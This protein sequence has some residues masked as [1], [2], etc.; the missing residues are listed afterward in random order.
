MTI[1][2][3]LWLHQVIVIRIDFEQNK[4]RFMYFYSKTESD[5]GGLCVWVVFFLLVCF[6]LG[7]VRIQQGRTINRKMVWTTTEMIKWETDM[8]NSLKIRSGCCWAVVWNFNQKKGILTNLTFLSFWFTENFTLGRFTQDQHLLLGMGWHVSFYEHNS[9]VASW[10]AQWLWL[11]CV[12]RESRG[13][14]S[15]SES[16]H[17]DGR[18][19]RV[20]KT[21]R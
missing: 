7:V 15:E 21:C 13:G 11:L 1:W 20:W 6:F 3:G 4:H 8:M 18:W 16:M 10:R 12:S 9:A 14:G 17:C 19:S 2:P 5:G